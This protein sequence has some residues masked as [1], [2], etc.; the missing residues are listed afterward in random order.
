MLAVNRRGT[1]AVDTDSESKVHAGRRQQ[2]QGPRQR[3]RAVAPEY[4]GGREY[5]I[6]AEFMHELGPLPTTHTA[7]GDNGTTD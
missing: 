7:A 6:E 4:G 5:D 3:A 2:P 1:L